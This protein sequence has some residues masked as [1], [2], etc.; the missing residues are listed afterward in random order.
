MRYYREE[1]E[2]YMVRFV[3]DDVDPQYRLWL[4]YISRT[5]ESGIPGYVMQEDVSR[6]LGYY[7]DAFWQ[8]YQDALR[9]IE[10]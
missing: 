8:K 9:K 4:E 7:F 3:A 5:F 6:I 10:P 2:F 1:A